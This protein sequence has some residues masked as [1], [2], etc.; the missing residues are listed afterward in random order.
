[1]TKNRKKSDT[2]RFNGYPHLNAG[3]IRSVEIKDLE[4]MVRQFKAKLADPDDTD[5]KRWTRR[6]LARME[7]ELSKKTEQRDKK[8]QDKLKRPPRQQ[9]LVSEDIHEM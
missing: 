7:K 8:Q 3:S 1:M 9:S 2:Y 4:V 6:W 5:D